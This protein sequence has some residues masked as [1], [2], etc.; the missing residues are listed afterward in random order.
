MYTLNGGIH[1]Y[2]NMYAM[3]VYMYILACVFILVDPITHVCMYLQTGMYL[4][5][6]R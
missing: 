3:H 5:P 4:E 1:I 6:V 2:S